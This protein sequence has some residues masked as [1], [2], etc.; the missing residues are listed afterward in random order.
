[1]VPTFSDNA[2]NSVPKKWLARFRLRLDFDASYAE[3]ER[4]ES[5]HSYS[6]RGRIRRLQGRLTEA[7]RDLN[8]GSRLYAQISNPGPQDRLRYFY[9]KTYQLNCAFPLERA[10]V[11][12]PEDTDI[13]CRELLE[14][15]APDLH[16]VAQ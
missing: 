8:T 5:F 4:Y 15:P 6:A 2:P 16:V 12:R 13:T 1:M 11:C 7:V 3:L 10:G 9:L 14:I